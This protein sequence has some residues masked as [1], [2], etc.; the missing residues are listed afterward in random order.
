MPRYLVIK[1][2]ICSRSHARKPLANKHCS[3]T[4]ATIHPRDAM[5]LGAEE[6]ETTQ[7]AG[8]SE[9]FVQN[10]SKSVIELLGYLGI[11]VSLL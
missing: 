2:E 10:V 5:H 7:L 4:L 9:G 6:I 11:N 1:R 3:I 8:V